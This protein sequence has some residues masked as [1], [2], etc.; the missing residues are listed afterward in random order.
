MVGALAVVGEFFVV[1]GEVVSVDPTVVVVIIQ[2]DIIRALLAAAAADVAAVPTVSPAVAVATTIPTV[3]PSVSVTATI[4]TVAPARF[5]LLAPIVGF[6]IVTPIVT[7][8]VLRRIFN[9]LLHH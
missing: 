5:L 2:L 1:A 6:I 7:Q 4:P 8:I 9:L 3:S